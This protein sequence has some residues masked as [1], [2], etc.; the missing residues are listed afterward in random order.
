[1]NSSKQLIL[2]LN[3]KPSGGVAFLA[4]LAHLA[5]IAASILTAPLLLARAIGLD[6]LQTVY[7]INASLG[8]SG[9]A[10]FI[11]VYKF[12]W[13]GSGLLSVQGTSFAFIGAMAY[14]SSMLKESMQIDEV[15][16]VLL[17]TSMVG[18]ILVVLASFFLI[19]IRKVITP[20]VTGVT[21]FLLGVSLLLSALT[22]LMNVY[23][24][25]S[26]MQESLTVLAEALI[27]LLVT[28]VL[29]S[30]ENMWCRLLSIP[31]GLLIGFLV[32]A[33]FGD[34]NAPPVSNSQI[35]S[36]LIPFRFPLGF[37]F[38]VLIIL[39]PIFLVSLT[40]TIGDITA[41]SSVSGLP[42]EGESY[43][44]RLRG[45][46]MADGVNTM[47][48]S[49]LGAFPN[50]TF[51]QN[52]AVIKVTGIASRRVGLVLAGLL[53][54]LGAIPLVSEIFMRIPGGVLN[55]ATGFLFLMIAYTGLQIVLN[56][57]EKSS[58]VILVLSCSLALLLMVAPTFFSGLNL[59]LPPYLTIILGFP[60]AT[61][62]LIAI[63]LDLFI[64]K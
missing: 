63:V 60:V 39:L 57:K 62:T 28:I 29:A 52:N 38:L 2:E 14:A 64:K 61:G 9:I 53:V 20:T 26:D 12:G 21:I 23:S 22:N 49:A 7:V 16:G 54:L 45:G 1:V 59:A 33:S 56:Q 10:T 48:A 36:I 25:A 44:D 18:A 32:A 43:L 19:Q 6:D 42:I 50:T 41:S 31:S 3:D 24:S 15:A 51:S 5:A 27:T 47:L 55:A 4:A 46:V 35:I 40:E 34:L 8:V 17:G 13:L 37:D 58:F 11:Q 30:R